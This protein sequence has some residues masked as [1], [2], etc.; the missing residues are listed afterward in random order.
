MSKVV[1]LPSSINDPTRVLNQQSETQEID[2][3]RVQIERAAHDLKNCMSVLLLAI[4]SLKDNG[5]QPAVPIGRRQGLEDL[6]T[7]MNRLVDEMVRLA[8]HNG[9][10]I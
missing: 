1:Y 4:S 2:I 9:K 6:V 7:E 8:E 3:C 5:N 10:T